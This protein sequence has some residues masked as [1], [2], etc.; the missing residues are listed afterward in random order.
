MMNKP[1]FFLFIAIFGA[2]CAAQEIQPVWQF[3]LDEGDLTAI[4]STG[5]QQFNVVPKVAE[6]LQWGEGRLGGKAVY[7][8]ND[9]M[10]ISKP[11]ASLEIPAAHSI[12]FSQPFT[13]MCWFKLDAQVRG[14]KQYTILGNVVS[15]YGPGF[16]VTY[17]WGTLYVMAGQ[18]TKETACSVNVSPAKV[19]IE[20][21]AW[22]HVAVTYDGTTVSIFINGIEAAS[23]TMTIYP[24][25]PRHFQIG[26][27]NA[28]AYGFVGA[29]SDV[30]IYDQPLSPEQ[31]LS[32]AKEF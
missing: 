10:C 21:D 17:G 3:K 7:F 27:Y 30:K 24:T 25:K 32:I 2:F 26:S 14:D 15:D 29:I 12:D 6:K 23:R 18:G 1:V 28:Y 8:K 19:K 13:A 5:N 11:V 20:R 22:Q 9:V 31:V 16:R 4:R